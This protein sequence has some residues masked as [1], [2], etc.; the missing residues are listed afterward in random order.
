MGYIKGFYTPIHPEKYLGDLNNIF[1]RSSWELDCMKFLDN[2]PNVKVWLSE[3]FSIPYVHPYKKNKDGT[4]KISQYWPDFYIEYMN[5]SGNTI[6]ETWEIKPIS[7]TKPSRSKNARRKLME[8]LI[9]SVN[10]AKWKSAKQYCDKNG[11]FFRVIT[12]KSL[13]K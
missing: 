1:H 5:K 9:V 8:N 4:A 11:I 6:K 10:I 7:Q 2:N 3:G 12:E 13:F